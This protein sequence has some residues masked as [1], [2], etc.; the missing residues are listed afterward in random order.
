MSEFTENRNKLIHK[1]RLDWKGISYDV[2]LYE[3]DSV[4]GL[5]PIT[6]VQA[7]PF[8]DDNHIVI[9]KHIDGYYGLPGGSVESGET[10]EIALKREVREE[11]ACEVL[12]C[13]MIGYMKNIRVGQEKETY[14]LRYWAKVKLLDEPIADPCGKAVAREVVGLG[15]AVEK[16][17]WGERG[18]ILI[19][20]AAK[21]FRQFYNG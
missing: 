15:T 7:I 6:Q 8:V 16:L 18:R 13:A 5:H 17:N 20:L 1:G 12:D 10:F 19:E 4:E 3:A 21:K 2:E 14:Q 11:I 9:Y